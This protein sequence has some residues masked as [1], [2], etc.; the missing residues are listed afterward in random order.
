MDMRAVVYRGP[1]RVQLEALD[2][3]PL[4]DGDL[5][6][7]VRAASVCATDMKIVAHGHFKIP[8][9]TSRVLGHEFV[10]EIVEGHQAYPELAKGMRVGVAPNVGCGRCQACVL[11]LD[12]LCPH[13]EALGI[14][15]DGA[16]AEYV[17]IPARMVRRG[18]VVPLPDALSDDEAALVEP[19][20]CV[21]AAQ[22]SVGLAAGD[23]VLVVGAGPMGLMHVLLAR[24]AG[25]AVV[26]SVD[27]LEPRRRLSLSLGADAALA[28]DELQDGV[29]TLTGGDGFDVIIVTVP[30]REAQEQ[31][32]GLAAV[33]GRIHFFAGLP[34]HS[35]LPTLDTNAIHYRQLTVTGTTGASVY[36]YRRTVQL[37]ASQRVSLSPLITHRMALEEVPGLFGSGR[38]A[39]QLKVLIHPR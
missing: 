35:A 7:R 19:F 32:I 22:E 8:E 34:K 20:S 28:P 31:A 1:G 11:G 17:R 2:R 14:T 21:V 10:G 39:D 5:L 38:P 13:Y 16:L 23:R 15:M 9:G 27:P 26:A 24:A 4:E 30:L 29:R 36:H 18:N 33:R 6:L 37:V 12:N 3:P 25:A